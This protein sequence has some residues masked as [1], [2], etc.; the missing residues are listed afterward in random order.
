MTWTKG[1]IRN[2]D[3]IPLAPEVTGYGAVL[4]RLPEGLTSQLHATLLPLCYR[5][6]PTQA[7]PA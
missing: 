4:L 2:G 6:T 5:D 3:A 1:E 7:R